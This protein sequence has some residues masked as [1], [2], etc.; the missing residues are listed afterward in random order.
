LPSPKST[1]RLSEDVAAIV[2]H[3][4]AGA[5]VEALSTAIWA[6]V[7]GLAFVNLYGKFD[8]STSAVVSERVRGAVH[9][10]ITASS[11]ASVAMH[12]A[13]ATRSEAYAA[14]WTLDGRR[15][16]SEGGGWSGSLS[17]ASGG[18]DAA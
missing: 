3:S 5:D 12:S 11:V 8:A 15:S 7:Y 17:S 13:C 10:V 6:L 2:R 18:T 14:R 1:P 16:V 4:F 9:A